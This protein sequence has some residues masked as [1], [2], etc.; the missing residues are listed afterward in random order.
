MSVG[1]IVPVFGTAPYL[2]ETLESVLGQ[3]PPPDDVIV[4]DDASPDPVTLDPLHAPRCRLVR[5]ERRGGPGAARDSALALLTTE[6]VACADAD[7][8]WLAGKL[9]AQ[10]RALTR[11][12]DVALC[13]GAAEIVGADGVPTGERW[14]T[15]PSGELSPQL[16]A[17]LLFERNPIPTSSVVVRRQ[18]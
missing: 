12:P 5:R 18:A 17:P 8:V 7:D 14:E 15:L 2:F 13:F 3:D 4:V 16:L 11:H 10:L 1:V 9:A 6:L